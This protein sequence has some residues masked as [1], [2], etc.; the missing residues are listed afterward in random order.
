M[1]GAIGDDI[2]LVTVNKCIARAW[3]NLQTSRRFN[4]YMRNKL[5]KSLRKVKVAKYFKHV[6]VQELKLGDRFPFI[7]HI[8]DLKQNE[9]GLWLDMDVDYI[10]P[11]V[12]TVR[13]R[14]I[15]IPADF[16]AKGTRP[17]GSR[18]TTTTT[19]GGSTATATEE[20]TR[21]ASHH[22][23]SEAS[24]NPRAKQGGVDSA[25]NKFVLRAIADLPFIKTTV[26]D[27]TMSMHFTLKRLRGRAVFNLP[28]PPT[29][30]LWYGFRH[31]PQM[32]IEFA[33]CLA[34]CCKD[35]VKRGEGDLGDLGE[36]E[37]GVLQSLTRA[38]EERMKIETEKTWVY[39]NMGNY[40][41]PYFKEPPWLV[42]RKGRV[43]RD[44]TIRN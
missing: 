38:M 37:R 27:R 10:G 15:R 23:T 25:V 21:A 19:T 12:A 2:N 3:Y 20:E 16:P 41:L 35:T 28:P 30:R 4:H 32:D 36:L 31:P 6:K 18:T 26:G 40:V 1:Q 44:G 33:F 9:W 14:G 29:D 7:T 22:H 43:D 17:S 24:R 11:F 8:E 5:T 39:P 34:D 42:A 13:A